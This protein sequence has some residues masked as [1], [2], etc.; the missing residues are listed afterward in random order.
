MNQTSFISP[1]LYRAEQY[2]H[3]RQIEVFDEKGSK[4]K[5]VG[6]VI[7]PQYKKTQLHGPHLLYDG[8]LDEVDSK[9]L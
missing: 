6:A 8:N 9:G 4:L 2:L 3:V 1:R 5:P 7:H